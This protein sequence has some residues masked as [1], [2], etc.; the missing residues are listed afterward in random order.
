MTLRDWKIVFVCVGLIVIVSLLAAAGCGVDDGAQ[1]ASVC[2]SAEP[3]HP[4]ECVD[5][6]ATFAN[7][8]VL[9]TANVKKNCEL[10]DPPPPPPPP[11]ET[12]WTCQATCYVGDTFDILYASEDCGIVGQPVVNNHVIPLSG[13]AVTAFDRT[14]AFIAAYSACPYGQATSYNGTKCYRTDPAGNPGNYVTV[15]CY[16]RSP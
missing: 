4:S 6:C 12:Q 16:A 9:A 2:S 15:S 8:A 11:P 14:T 1:C 13:Q 5:A 10:T 3:D 7:D